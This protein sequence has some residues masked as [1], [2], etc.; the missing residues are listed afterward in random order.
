MQSDLSTFNGITCD[1]KIIGHDLS[2]HELGESFFESSYLA[3]VWKNSGYVK[4]RH[5]FRENNS[6]VPL[7][8]PS[9][10]SVAQS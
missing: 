8:T 4:D 5:Q 7:L 10:V 1:D 9:T 2:A 3:Q 6:P